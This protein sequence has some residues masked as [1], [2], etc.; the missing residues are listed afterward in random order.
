MYIFVNLFSY[1]LKSQ[2]ETLV[3]IQ[4]IQENCITIKTIYCDA[5]HVFCTELVLFY[6]TY[7]HCA[8]SSNLFHSHIVQKYIDQM[9]PPENKKCCPGKVFGIKSPSDLWTFEQEKP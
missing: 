5:L 3:S 7:S 4:K 9:S 8:F 6:R 1:T 2:L